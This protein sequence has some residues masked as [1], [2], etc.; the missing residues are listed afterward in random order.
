[1]KSWILFGFALLTALPAQAQL[2]SSEALG[3]AALGGLVGGIIGNN[4]GKKSAE[5]AAIGAGAGLL[6]GSIVHNERDRREYYSSAPAYSSP[7]SVAG[8]P[9]YYYP[10]PRPNYAVSG[11]VVGG[12]AGGVIGHNNRCQT[13]EGVAIGAGAGLLLGTVAE[14]NARRHE[15]AILYAPA[16]AA[17]TAPVPQPS[18][19]P[20][21]TATV[22]ATV[23]NSYN[24][25]GSVSPMS[26]ANSLFGR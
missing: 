6:L 14:Q 17:L 22:Q 24:S 25:S 13:A 23:N 3:G 8:S 19:A 26:Q 5:G 9:A 11:A 15:R 7:A 4:N 12:I 16:P 1:M 18:P 21:D 10:S 20:Q 2:F